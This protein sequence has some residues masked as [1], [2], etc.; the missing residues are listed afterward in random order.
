MLKTIKVSEEAY[1]AVKRLGREIEKEKAIEG[2][3]NVSLTTAISFA[4]NRTLED[5]ERN[6]R[7]KAAAGAWSEKAAEEVRKLI[8]E[9]RRFRTRDVGFC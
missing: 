6:R 8:H 2:I 4:V 5:M 7:F 3:Y 9:T 1:K